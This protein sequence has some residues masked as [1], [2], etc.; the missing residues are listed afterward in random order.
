MLCPGSFVVR[1][2]YRVR[3]FVVKDPV[4][5]PGMTQYILSKLRAVPPE[6]QEEGKRLAT[7]FNKSPGATLHPFGGPSIKSL[8]I[9]CLEQ[10][11][12]YLSSSSILSLRLSCRNLRQCIATDQ[13]FYR[14]QLLSGQIF[15]LQDLDLGLI[16]ERWDEIKDKD[17]RRLVRTLARYENFNAGEG[18]SG[19]L[20]ELH[21]APIGL[22]NRLRIIKIVQGIFSGT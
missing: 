22:K 19:E 3:Q 21:D 12:A 16:Q 17:W 2:T 20:G 9:E 8:P 1:D 18:G 15:A 5:V 14:Q 4:N 13:A 6:E 10:I 7:M 11:C